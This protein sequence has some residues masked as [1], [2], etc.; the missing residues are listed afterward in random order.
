MELQWPL[1]VFT[2]LVCLGAGTFG[3]TGLLAG[4]GKAQE[5]QAPATLVSLVAIA[6]GGIASF[7]HLEHWDRIFNGFG[8]LESGIT[9][10]LIGI[11]VFAIVALAYLV[12]I[13]RTGAPRWAGW[14]ALGISVVLVV[15]MSLSYTMAARLVWNT[16]LLPVYYLANAAL[17]GSLVVSVIT[18]M[19]KADAGLVSKITLVAA[20]FMLVA[21]VAYGIYIPLS[22]SSFVSV[23]NYFDPT[24]PTRA[25]AEPQGILSGFLTGEYALLFWGGALV[26]GAA[27]PV[28]LA[29]LATRRTAAPTGVSA[30]VAL[31]AT[32]ALCALGGGLCFRALLYVLGFS[33]FVFY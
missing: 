9:Q 2:L 31:A 15:V 32:S 26:L 27:V 13:R 22:A 10:E 1:M 25:T 20:I 14:V 33:V 21:V 8:H 29:F 23:G 5:V 11:A 4:F 12:L 18:V 16:P 30:P 28:V 19:K 3:V 7:L 6:A 17:F 24:Q